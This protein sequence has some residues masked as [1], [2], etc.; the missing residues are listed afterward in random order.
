MMRGTMNMLEYWFRQSLIYRIVFS[1]VEII[2]HSFLARAV[3]FIGRV[4][5]NSKIASCLRYVAL[6]PY[7]PQKSIFS[8]MAEYFN[9][10]TMPFRDKLFSFLQ[11]SWIYRV[12]ASSRVFHI[13]TLMLIPSV[14][15]YAVIDE[16]GRVIFQN[17]P[18]FG[19]WDEAYLILCA[20]Y[21]FLHWF[22]IKRKPLNITPVTAPMFL[23]ISVAFYLYLNN[24]TYP[25]LG[26]DGFRIIVQYVLW[27][28][29]L[30]SFLTD[31]NK[32][33]LIVRLLVYTGGFMGIHGIYQ[34]IVKVPTP[35]H[36]TDAAEGTTATR[37]F[38]IV[39]SPNILG[40]IFTLL[41]PICL[42]LVLQKKRR[43]L[44]REIYFM[45]FGAMGISL[46]LTLS[47]GAWLGAAV[48]M[49]VFC[50]AVNPRWLLLLIAGG[51]TVL[52]VPS[53][54]NRIQYLLSPQYF[55]SSMTGGRLMR[56]QI[57]LEMFKQNKWF[58]VGLGHFGGAVAM[59][60]QDLIP[61]TFYMDNYWLK[62]AV[63]M[64]CFGLAAFCLLMISLI[65]WS[66]RS[67]KYNSDSDIKLIISGGFAGLCGII[68]HN[69]VEN[70]F[71]VP[72]MVVYFWVVAALVFYFGLRRRKLDTE[73]M[74]QTLSTA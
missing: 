23:L 40:S 65:I 25:Q 53:V 28:F 7:N 21:V 8:R 12:L 4:L 71:E 69:L 66:V 57:G 30:N 56:Y 31:D 18:F 20:L 55:I 47:R 33:Y 39:E 48:A 6:Y 54:L 61:D 64:G 34:Y 41:I 36:W 45:L 68:T 29:V 32:A 73:K 27:F 2:N 17:I 58:G 9:T 63:E 37:V 38:S 15:F 42:A 11:L 46:I 70:V 13:I 50:L 5:I 59:N 44:D 1:L 14:A 67:I 3:E 51:S 60:N 52:F 16:A 22:F 35:V 74:E 10:K 19:L 24:S 43:F 62:T 72:Y 26:F 49:F